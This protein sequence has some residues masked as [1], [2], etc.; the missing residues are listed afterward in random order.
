MDVDLEAC[1]VELRWVDLE[2]GWW[3]LQISKQ[4]WDARKADNFEQL[5]RPIVPGELSRDSLRLEI[6]DETRAAEDVAAE[7]AKIAAMLQACTTKAPRAHWDVSFQPGDWLILG[8]ETTG[9]DT[10]LL[11]ARSDRT[12]RIPQLPG[13]RC[14]N[15][16]T[17]AGIG[18]FEA[19]RQIES[20][21]TAC[22]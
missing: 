22:G 19:L 6:R 14:L 3:A 16:A 1:T 5:T 15:L 4:V 21:H 9:L 17:A 13:E 12:L 8:S 10:A 18:L 2:T 7:Q 20:R 11:A